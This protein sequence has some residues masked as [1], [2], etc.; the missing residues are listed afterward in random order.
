MCYRELVLLKLLNLLLLELCALVLLKLL[1][2]FLKKLIVVSYITC[3][4][5][6]L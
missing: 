3:S 5:L 2:L 6:E 4:R 1:N